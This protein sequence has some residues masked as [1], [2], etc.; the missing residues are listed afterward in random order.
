MA[1]LVSCRFGERPCLKT[2]VKLMKKTPC[3]HIHIHTQRDYLLGELSIGRGR[4]WT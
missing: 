1:E 3:T 4:K 2:K